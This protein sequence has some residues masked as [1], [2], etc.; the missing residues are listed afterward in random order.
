M[1]TVLM[2]ALAAFAIGAT[3][4]APA[5]SA[6]AG[7]KSAIEISARDWRTTGSIVS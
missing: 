2:L 1:K 7:S 3:I 5:D 6:S 4:A